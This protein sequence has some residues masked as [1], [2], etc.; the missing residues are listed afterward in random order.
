MWQTISNTK[1]MNG[2]QYQS[3]GKKNDKMKEYVYVY[4]WMKQLICI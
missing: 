4:V 2:F 3:E 1:E